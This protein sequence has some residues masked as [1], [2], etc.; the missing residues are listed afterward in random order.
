MYPVGSDEDGDNL[1]LRDG[2]V[3]NGEMSVRLFV[4]LSMGPYAT[5]C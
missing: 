5:L 2:F 4:V 1:L 3:D